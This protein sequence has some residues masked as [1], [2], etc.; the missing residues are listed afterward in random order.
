MTTQERDAMT[1]FTDEHGR[2]TK[3][4]I[5]TKTAIIDTYRSISFK[6]MSHTDEPTS[7]FIHIE[8]GG[9]G[10]SFFFDNPHEARTFLTRALSQ[11]DLWI[12]ELSPA[13]K[14]K[15]DIYALFKKARESDY[16]DPGEA[17]ELLE[18]AAQL[19]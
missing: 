18:R 5:E 3:P 1:K 16:T 4:T 17:Q 19:L 12:N 13:E 9:P 7:L 11:V 14:L 10:A 8:D 2:T 6:E 15:T